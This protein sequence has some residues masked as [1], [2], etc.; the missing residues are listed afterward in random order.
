MEFEGWRDGAAGSIPR[1]QVP[2]PAVLI[3]SDPLDGG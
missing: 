1:T 3:C 2:R